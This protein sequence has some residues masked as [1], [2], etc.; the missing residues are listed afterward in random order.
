VATDRRKQIEDAIAALGSLRGAV[1]S[2]QSRILD[3]VVALL[4]NLDSELASLSAKLRWHASAPFRSKKDEA[5]ESQLAFELLRMLTGR[6][7]QEPTPTADGAHPDEVDAPSSDGDTQPNESNKADKPSDKNSPGGRGSRPNRERR[8]QGLRRKIAE[9]K[10]EDSKIPECPCCTKRLREM[11]FDVRE[12]FIYQPADVYILE[13]RIYKYGCR[14]AELVIR[15]EPTEPPKPIPG[16][17]ASSSLLAQQAIGKVLDGNPVDRFAKQL[18]RQD[19]DL[20]K[21]TLHDWF[22]RTGDMLGV[23]GTACHRQLLACGLISLDDTPVRARNADHPANV[24]TGRQWLYLGDVNQIA[25]AAFTPDWKGTHPRQVLEGARGDIQNDGY[26]GINPLF[27]GPGAP[28]RLGCN[29]H[30]R[31][32]FVHALEQGDRRS[33]PMIDLYGALYHVERIATERKLDAIGRLALRQAESVP[34]WRELERVVI[35]LTP[36]VESKAPLGRAIYYWTRQQPFL[37]AFLDDGRFPISNAHVERL[38]RVVSTFR[39]NSLLVDSLDAGK[40]YANVLTVLLN[41]ELAGVNPYVYLVDVIDKIAADWPA[42]RVNE[43][44]PR[45]WLAARQAE[46]PRAGQADVVA[47]T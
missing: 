45:A 10:V 44:L 26:A 21:S 12:R 17:M 46:Q 5:P 7:G 32:K 13:E 37:R 4:A 2:E 40:R 31:R 11:G 38:L 23:L 39:K 18:R 24:Q 22:G 34:L 25:Y 19:I 29:D 30:G 35:D 9:V 20:A 1:A 3:E 41:C 47:V 6:L 36:K 28:R 15:A 14:C 33:Q 16:G 8:G 42:D 43:L 27:V